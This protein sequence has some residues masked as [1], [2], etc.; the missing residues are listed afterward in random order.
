MTTAR[1][2]IESALA[3]INKLGADE[4]VSAEDGALC[5][6]R[7][8]ALVD[9]W[10]VED[11]FAYTS[12]ETIF[13]LNSGVTSLTVGPGQDIDIARPTRIMRGSFTRLSQLDYR[14]TPVQEPEY[15]DI[16]LKTISSLVPVVCFYDGGN[17]T[18]TVFFYPATSQAAEVHLIT[19]E[20]G[21]QAVD[22]NTSYFLPQGYQRAIEFNLA[23]EIAP[24]F[25]AVPSPWVVAN[26]TSS[27]RALKLMNMTIPE[28]DVDYPIGA[29]GH[30]LAD[31]YAG[32]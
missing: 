26:A 9:S 10:E 28:M 24:D 7:L 23:V 1:Q 14:L 25:R 20:P 30:S 32:V 12:L 16:C 27:K 5:L 17:P 11:L 4:T 8:N 18:G 31:F 3:K 2:L 13:T 29:R 19:P 15:N 6:L 21:G 22:L